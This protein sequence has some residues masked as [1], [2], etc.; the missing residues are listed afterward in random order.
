VVRQRKRADER[1]G[2]TQR[3]RAGT[4]EQRRMQAPFLVRRRFTLMMILVFAV[5]VATLAPNLVDQLAPRVTAQ[6][7]ISPLAVF[8]WLLMVLAPAGLAWWVFIDAGQERGRKQA[9]QQGAREREDAQRREAERKAEEKRRAEERR[10]Q[11][12][13]EREAERVRQQQREAKQLEAKEWW[14]VLEVSPRASAAEIRGAYHRK[15]KQCHPDRVAG[16]A[17][18]FIDLAQKHTQ[19]LN[20]AYDEATRACRGAEMRQDL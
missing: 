4:F 1:E 17:P 19:M 10:R 14:S 20:A 6:R 16:L 12:E 5:V 11:A 2:A 15:I 8:G 18:E 7:A 3:T 9:E 13:Q